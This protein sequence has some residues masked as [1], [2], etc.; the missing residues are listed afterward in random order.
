MSN[1][2]I[3]VLTSEDKEFYPPALHSLRITPNTHIDIIKDA[4]QPWVTHSA[5]TRGT[6]V[7]MKFCSDVEAHSSL[8]TFMTANWVVS[9]VWTTTN[10]LSLIEISFFSFPP[11]RSGPMSA[12]KQSTRLFNL[13]RIPQRHSA[14]SQ[15]VEHPTWEHLRQPTHVLLWR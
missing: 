13:W 15:R 4:S 6:S 1:D 11:Q 5:V 2:S 3:E 7:R 8:L 10:Y 14:Q 12:Q 9:E